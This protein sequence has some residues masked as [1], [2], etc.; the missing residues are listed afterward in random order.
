M[1]VQQLRQSTLREILICFYLSFLSTELSSV[2]H[3]KASGYNEVK[4][5]GSGQEEVHTERGSAANDGEL[6]DVF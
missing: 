3:E 2:A 4:R 5:K 6:T 1:E